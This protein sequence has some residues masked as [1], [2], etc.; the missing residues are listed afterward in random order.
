MANLKKKPCKSDI[1]KKTIKIFKE[2]LHSYNEKQPKKIQVSKRRL[3][4][5]AGFIETGIYNESINIAN[6]SNITACWKSNI[7][8]NLYKNICIDIYS[9]LNPQ[10]YINNKR[11]IS[12]L[13]EKE[14]HPKQIASMEYQRMFPEVWKDILDE[15]NKRDRYLYEINTEMTTDS[16]TCS[17]CHKKE[18]TYY[19]LQTRS[20]DE[21]MT[22]FVTCLNCG[23]RWRC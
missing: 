2:L 3:T 14:F 16:Y 9:N 4:V 12:R 21:P 5:A 13:I 1:R 18:C 10:T 17:R 19:Q 11:L 22:T 6:K 20:A 23:K 15:K 7:F 8:K